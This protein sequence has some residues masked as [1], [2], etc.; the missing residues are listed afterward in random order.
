MLLVGGLLGLLGTVVV[1]NLLEARVRNDEVAAIRTL[2]AVADAQRMVAATGLLDTNADGKGE[3][4]FLQEL[5]GEQVPRA[6][7]AIL[8]GNLDML[9]RGS[10]PGPLPQ[11]FLRVNEEGEAVICG[12][13]FRVY[14][15]SAKG[16]AVAER[17]ESGRMALSGEVSAE[18]SAE[19][20]CAYAVPERR[21]EGFPPPAGRRSFFINQAGILTAA[22]AGYGT[23]ATAE[24]APSRPSP[25]SAFATPGA[26]TAITGAMALEAEGRDGLVWS[27]VR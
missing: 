26:G 9:P 10:P 7:K 27:E 12:Y 1:P 2:R 14:L 24:F 25:G 4:A 6:G 3:F 16:E 23:L 13:V 19:T 15:P 17:R 21:A 8:S 20:W 5:S 11:F 22:D 18:R